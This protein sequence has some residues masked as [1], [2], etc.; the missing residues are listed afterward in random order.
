MGHLKVVVA[1][2][3]LSFAFPLVSGHDTPGC[4]DGYIDTNSGNTVTSDVVEVPA[5]GL[6]DVEP[7]FYV[8]L[9]RGDAVNAIAVYEEENLVV[10]LQTS[11]RMEVFDDP[12]C[13]PHFLYD[14]DKRIFPTA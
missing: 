4:T 9:N 7:A 3:A 12:D 5:F 6:T 1:I 8:A 13:D 11:A 14:A 2:V 10:R